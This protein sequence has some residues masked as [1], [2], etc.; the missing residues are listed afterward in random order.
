MFAYVNQVFTGYSADF[1]LIGNAGSD[2][3]SYIYRSNTVSPGTGMLYKVN[4][5]ANARSGVYTDGKA[6]YAATRVNS[7]TTRSFRNGT[8][9]SEDTGLNSIA[10]STD[11]A[12]L[13][14]EN[15]VYGLDRVMGGGYGGTLTD[16]EMTIFMNAYHAMATALGGNY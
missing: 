5:Y 10:V 2:N 7:T 11:T 9:I 4:A 16:S 13:L 6:M 15:T 3:L 8:R 1:P 12:C 14:R